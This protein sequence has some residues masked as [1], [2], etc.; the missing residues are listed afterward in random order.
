MPA[1]RIRTPRKKRCLSP[2]GSRRRSTE[3]SV[4]ATE[5]RYTYA[6]GRRKSAIAR[7]QLSEGTGQIIVNGR[8]VDDALPRLADQTAL[9]EPFRLTNSAGRFSV[10]AKGSGR[11]T[12]RWT[13]AL[14]HAVSRALSKLS[15]DYR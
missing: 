12:T 4:S 3:L 15:Y 7:V 14:V 5:R 2:M 8:P 9:N 10:M 1:R 6:T 13:S 11:G